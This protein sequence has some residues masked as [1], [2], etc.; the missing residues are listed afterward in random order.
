MEEHLLFRDFEV[1]TMVLEEQLKRESV[2]LSQFELETT[3]IEKGVL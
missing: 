3:L 2:E 1:E